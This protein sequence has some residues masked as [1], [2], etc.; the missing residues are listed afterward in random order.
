MQTLQVVERKSKLTGQAV[1]LESGR[2]EITLENGT[3]KD[4]APSSFKRQFT[5]SKE[6][7]EVETPNVDE[8]LNEGD[9]GEVEEVKH[10]EEVENVE[11]FNDVNVQED[12]VEEVAPVLDEVVQ[13]EV[14]NEHTDIDS[15][16]ATAEEEMNSAVNEV[17][18]STE[19]AEVEEPATKTVDDL[20]LNITLIDWDMLGTRG[21]KTDKVLSHVTIKGYKMEIT[22]Y[23]GFIT[24]VKLFEEC[25]APENDPDANWRL[26]YKSPKS[27]LKDTLEWLG[28]DADDMKIARKEITAIRKIVKAEHLANKSDQ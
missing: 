13:E 21:G 22:E 26:A 3:T 16:E 20:G 1:E 11:D 18:P 15:E 9:A 5:V 4:L 6:V 25:E 23:S 7:V 19:V 8:Q 2:F 14:T 28:L 12:A 17:A 10:E 27:S 24:D